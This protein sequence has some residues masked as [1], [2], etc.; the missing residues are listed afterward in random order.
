MHPTLEARPNLSAEKTE[1]RP[2]I[3]GLRVIGSLL[4]IFAL[5]LFATAP[6]EWK[7]QAVLGGI[8]FLAALIIDRRFRGR[9]ATVV[10][11]IISLFCTAR[12]AWWR[13][14]ET[15]RHLLFNGSQT[16]PLELFFVMLL[17]LAEA[18]AVLILALGYLQSVRPLR[19]KPAPLPENVDEWPSVD[20]FI[21]TYNEPVDVVRSTVL[22]ALNIDWPRDRM[23]VYL[24][25]DG[26]RAEV[27]A[28]AEACGAHYIA[29][30][31]NRHAKAGNINHAL[32]RTSA[33]YVAIFDS[34]HIPTR[35]FLQVT[36]GWFL[37]D[38]KLALVQ[39]PHHFYSADPFERNLGTFRRIPNEGELFYGVL[40]D[41]NDFWNAAF[42][43]GSCAVIRRAALDQI[44]GIAT[45]TVTEDSHTALRLQRLGWSTAY[46]SIPQAAGLATAN[47]SDHITQRIRWARGMVQILRIENPLF[48]RG[49]KWH[50][51]LCY[52]NGVIHFL[53][54]APRLIFLT[55]PLI[56]L[57]LG[58]SNL[59]GYV[60]A[61]LAYVF[62]HLL[63]SLVTNSRVHG[64]HRHSFWNEVFETV[65]APYIL[66]PTLLALINP[67][68][69]KFNV[70]PKRTVVTKS[71]FDLR[72]AAP[73]LVLLA[74]NLAG[75]GVAI[76]QWIS[77]GEDQG[78]LVVNVIW[79]S[80]NI[81]VL[82]ATLAVAW[83][84]RQLR[85]HARTDLRLPIR[86]RLPH[87]AEVGG[88]TLD[89]S[90][91][92]ASIQV[93]RPCEMGADHRAELVFGTDEG[94]VALPVDVRRSVGLCLGLKFNLT[95][96][97]EHE[98]LTRII[99][100]RADAWILWSK[101]RL[102]D[103][104]LRSLSRLLLISLRGILT[105]PKA[106]FSGPESEPAEPAPARERQPVL[107]AIAL[108]LLGFFGLHATARAAEPFSDLHDLQALGQQEPIRFRGGDGRATLTFGVPV[109][110]IVTDAKLVLELRSSGGF[111][112]E[113]SRLN[114]ALN[115][116][117]LSSVPV[118][119]ADGVAGEVRRVEITLPPDLVVSDN[120]MTLQLAAAC[121]A[122]C[123][124]N[125]NWV[126]VETSTSLRI[127][128]TMLPL[129]DSLRVL[130]APFFD[131][132][133]H[134]PVRVE[135]LFTEAPD[136]TTLQAAGVVA[137]W[138]GM[139]ADDRPAHFPVRTGKIQQGDAIVLVRNRDAAEAGLPIEA[140]GGARIK[141][142]T[143]P[144]DP[145]GK[146]LIVAGDSSEQILQAAQALAL[147]RYSTDGDHADVADP[148][149]PSPSRP[150]DAPRW[151]N[152]ERPIGLGEGLS[153]EQL[154]LYGSGALNLYFRLPPD[155][156][157]GQRSTVPARLNFRTNAA[158]EQRGEMHIRLNGIHVTS[159]R[160][161]VPEGA[162]SQHQTVYLPVSAL[163][164]GNTLTI[165]FALAPGSAPDRYP[166]ISVLP[167]SAIDLRGIPRYVE[168]PRLDL[169][170]QAG[171]PF[172]RLADL[173]GTAVVLPDAPTAAE[174]S[175]YLELIGRF[176]AHTGSPALRVSVLGPNDVRAGISKDLLV[177]GSS[178]D[179]P[180]LSRWSDS[181]S[182]RMDGAQVRAHELTGMWGVLAR[183][184][185]TQ[186]GRESRRLADVLDGNTPDGI[187]QGFPSPLDDRHTVV[188]IGVGS[189]QNLEALMQALS[190]PGLRQIKGNV[191]LLFNGRF[192]SFALAQKSTYLGELSPI[193]SFYNWVGA[194][195]YVIV[196]A[197][198]IAAL[199]LS[200]WFREW[201]DRHAAMRLEG[202]R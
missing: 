81:F 69:G 118:Q 16:P 159:V 94:E 123:K 160:V 78:T 168:L 147:S 49:L 74:L 15:T 115:G 40:Q 120:T 111:R 200:R 32:A 139:M 176:A 135:I 125:E 12:Y 27:H 161:T 51:R 60:W 102:D 85:A 141:I 90:T 25:D 163:Y 190:G 110:K 158:A 134:R 113:A 136:R 76:R 117:A 108:A 104:P 95:R 187:V 26:K 47:I 195:F 201:S 132:S 162:S 83:E 202:T 153:T 194:N 124:E 55:A 152:P 156:A 84:V 143:N 169:F 154:R 92:G 196:F 18:Y 37:K 35:S 129:P 89:M 10:L 38:T 165:E 172:T 148:R 36:M 103:R 157:F 181:M 88:V 145:Y 121:P 80:L 72:I 193:E 59:Y 116:V 66:L 44:G 133:V 45:E 144:L 97:V 177:I 6:L 184:P 96:L 39:T 174:I 75:L 43:C 100:G 197:L 130:P 114:V 182:V 167:G 14:S 98:A 105:I 70:T 61:I 146:L 180:L 50:Q 173:S 3:R 188:T 166:E 106:L 127:A 73:F 189:Q 5:G 155:L 48:G 150:Y 192:Q 19:R 21:P 109:T 63:L 178:A 30:L 179:Q 29:R 13:V 175:C 54:A 149:A 8:L 137:S 9:Q 62:P 138:I 86:L 77:A 58:W 31:D 41:G 131:N 186:A 99:F 199:P 46:L 126:Q 91:C 42:F 20:V 7:N 122:G 4:I 57:L 22:A 11:M 79:T 68:W 151:L 183:I 56:Y 164:P 2:R 140:S 112:P 82:G 33:E 93:D 191:A 24:L 71:Y 28:L 101:G 1:T 52:F 64:S 185:F 171:F 128:G 23:N 34:D 67:R 53:N 65:L 87:G 170:T 107:P 142:C 17:M 198:L 119:P